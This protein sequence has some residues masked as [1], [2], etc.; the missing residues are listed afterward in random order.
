MS[1]FGQETAAGPF[2]IRDKTLVKYIGGEEAV[3]IPPGIMSIGD[4]AFSNCI[5]LSSVSIPYG[6]TSIGDWV[7]ADCGSLTSIQHPR[8]R[9]VYRRWGVFRMY[10]PDNHRAFPPYPDR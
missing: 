6:V 7:F 2:E 3:V 9:Y 8:K 10:Q 5:S 1:V 4:R